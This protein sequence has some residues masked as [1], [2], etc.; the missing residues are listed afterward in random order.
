MDQAGTGSLRMHALLALTVYECTDD[1][2][3]V[4]LSSDIGLICWPAL[5]SLSIYM[6]QQRWVNVKCWAHL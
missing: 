4:G 2:K 5:Y 6:L 3:A 1:Q